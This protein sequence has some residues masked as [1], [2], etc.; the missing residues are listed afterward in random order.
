MASLGVVF[1]E[2]EMTNWLKAWLAI[3]IVK[4][5][6]QNFVDEELGEFKNNIYQAV[7]SNNNLSSTL[8]CT[9]CSTANLLKC[10]IKGM[11]KRTGNT[12]RTAHADP[13]KQCKPC[14]N[15]ICDGIR[16]EIIKA[17]R[18][19]GPSWKNT[20]AEHWTS[21]HW[22]VAKCF[23]PPD[24]YTDVSSIQNTDFNGVI[25]VMLNCTHFDSKMSFSIS[26]QNS[27]IPCLLTKVK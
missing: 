1:S 10:P 24:G 26:P 4:D 18:F 22:E 17:H 25:S 27:S 7:R 15:R 3:N 9:S 12:C 11:C 8:V 2:P 6:L 5:G 21:N 23:M 19:N 20:S 16:D 13:T 14:P